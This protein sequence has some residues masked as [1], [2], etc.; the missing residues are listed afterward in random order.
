MVV[1]V[2]VV[3]LMLLVAELVAVSVLGWL[4]PVARIVALEA[5][6]TGW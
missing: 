3:V 4:T 6:L 2:T 5:V 1:M